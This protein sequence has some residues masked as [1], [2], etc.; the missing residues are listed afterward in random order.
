MTKKLLIAAVALALSISFAPGCR[1][2][3]SDTVTIALSEKF[4]GL[5]TL[6]NPDADAAA[7]RV[8]NLLYNS[9]VKKNEKF[10]YVG[11]L[12]K[13]IAIGADGLTITFTLHD[14]VTFHN[15]QALTSAD[16]RYT[17]DSLFSSETSM[18]AGSFF[19]SIP[20]PSDPEG[21][22][23]IR[24]PHITAVETPDAR[25]VVMRVGRPALVNQTLSNLVTIPMIPTGTFGTQ[26][27]SPVGSGPFRFENFD[28]VNSQVR[29]VAFD[30][31]W[32]GPPKIRSL[33]VKTVPDANALQAEL[34]SGGVDV[35]PLPA[36]LAPDTIKKLVERVPSLKLHESNGSNIQYLGFN[37]ESPVFKDV[38]VR[39]AVAHAIDR[40]G[41]IDNLMAGM[42]RPADSILPIDSWAYVAS[43][44][45]SYDPEKAKTL[46]SQAG[47][48]GTPVKFKFA[49]NTAA[50]AQ[51][52]QVIQDS[53]KKVGMTVELETVDF[54]TLLAQL[55]Q[56]Q[57]EMTIGR[58]V[59]G[60]QDPIFL[61]DLFSSAYFPDKRVD[62]RNRSRYSNA[63][64][65]SLIE[66]AVNAGDKGKALDFYRQAQTIVA[67]DLPLLPLWYPKN[68]VI[69]NERIG[70]VSINASGDWSFIKDLTV[71]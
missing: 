8:R 64:F 56:G 39:Q 40:Q 61:R 15:G 51:Y 27:D 33:T 68:I 32:E 70:N 21:R 58:W 65:D 43:D 4:S 2:G 3:D 37:V 19:D 10:E 11:E 22:K 30:G 50:V 25:T 18:K 26:K 23:R 62:G 71:R 14:N 9:L 47:Y 6:S 44:G 31:Y 13:D 38:R 36:N 67:R 45:V 52:A 29:L 46:L 49:S 55:K 60:N 20:D 7:D 1:R 53:L 17:L 59:G 66:Q 35:A 54:N 57:F 34:Q 5:D 42:A 28:Q 16:V 24:T 41:I 48:D 12:A 63:E 69:A